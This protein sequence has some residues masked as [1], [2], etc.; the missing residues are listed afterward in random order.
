MNIKL[1]ATIVTIAVVITGVAMIVPMFLQTAQTKGAPRQKLMLSFSVTQ[2]SESVEWCKSLSS[3]LDDSAIGATVFIVGKVAEQ[4]PECVSYFS[5]KVDIGSQTYSNID[6]TGIADYLLKL[7]EVEG[8]KK[9]VDM[10]G[11]LYSQVFRAPFYRTDQ[12]IYSLLSRSGIVADF[13]YKNQYNVYMEGQF[14]R[15][16]AAMFNGR[17]LSTDSIP[18]LPEPS[19]P[20]II[21]FEDT[22]SIDSI[23]A[24]LSGLKADNFEFVNASEIVGF[25][26]TE[27]L[28]RR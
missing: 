4:H 5:E 8:G 10:A 23:S 19:M 7:K 11:N 21:H 18:I 6:L 2:D 16:N 3:L 13:S 22:D 27:R 26:L 25:A 17:D 1:T 12:D 20:L 9:A 24:F 14:L 15:F 28:S